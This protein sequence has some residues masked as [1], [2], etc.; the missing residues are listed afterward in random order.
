MECSADLEPEAVVALA[1]VTQM[2]LPRFASVE[3]KDS[4]APQNLVPVA[5]L[6]SHLRHQLGQTALL[7]RALRSA[8]HA[9]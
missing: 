4:R 6:E 7:S 9:G 2:V 8:A 3:Y 1:N 5:A